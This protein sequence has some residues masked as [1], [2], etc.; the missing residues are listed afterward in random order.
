MQDT[1]LRIDDL[2]LGFKTSKGLV[3]CVHDVSVR[4]SSGQIVGLVGESGSGKSLTASACLGLNAPNAYGRGTITVGSHHYDI[5]D[6]RAIRRARGREICMIFQ[7]PMNAFNPVIEIGKVLNDIIR[8]RFGV[9][10]ND[11]QC[12]AL[13]ALKSVQM[14]DPEL[15]LRCFPHQ[16]SGGQLQ[17]VMIAAAI[18]CKPNI[19]IADEPTTA[20]DVSVQDS[21]LKLIQSMAGTSAMGVLF[22]THDLAVVSQICSY[23]YVM[24]QGAIVESGA[25]T[26][27]L[28][29]PQHVYTQQ[30]IQSIPELGRPEKLI[31]KQAV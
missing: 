4:V 16:L 11:A 1:E 3:E 2:H 12:I 6:T 5:M 13:D 20:L 10:K 25:T 24:K 15:K 28:Q 23:V 18:A 29:H 31:V 8:K 27:V 14:P 21:I 9:N 26:H 7:N 19:L 22:I 30:L 17:R